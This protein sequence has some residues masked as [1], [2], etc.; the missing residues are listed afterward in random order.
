MK[1][2]KYLLENKVTTSKSLISNEMREKIL[3]ECGPYLKLVRDSRRFI[4]RGLSSLLP[5]PGRDIEY[6][7]IISVR[8]NRKSAMDA[9]TAKELNDWL[10]KHGHIRRDNAMIGISSYHSADFFGTPCWVFP[11]GNFNF[12]FAKTRDLNMNHNN[13]W[14]ENTI[15][16]YF[17]YKKSMDKHGWDSMDDKEA[18][19]T[20]EL[21]ENAFTTNKDFKRAANNGFEIWF[22]CKKYFYVKAEK[23]VEEKLYKEL[24]G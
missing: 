19:R 12:T 4:Y 14:R 11:I 23:G 18:E 5:I 22:D 21:F 6:E 3:K 15:E 1:F 2:K 24:F 8:Q 7:G 16:D 9:K 17:R 20:I 13:G 10:E